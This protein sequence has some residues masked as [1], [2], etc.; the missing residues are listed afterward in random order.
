MSNVSVFLDFMEYLNRN[1]KKL[2]GMNIKDLC[3]KA[4]RNGFIKKDDIVTRRFIYMC[5]LRNSVAHGNAL[6]ASELNDEEMLYHIYAYGLLI[7]IH[8]SREWYIETINNDIYCYKNG[9][10]RIKF[11]KLLHVM[12]KD[13]VIYFLEDF[14]R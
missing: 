1:A 10:L 7:L 11:S 12:K 5:D 2:G 8:H 6:L 9:Q 13:R 14:Y 3:Y 4:I